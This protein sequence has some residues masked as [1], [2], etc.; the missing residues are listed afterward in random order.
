MAEGDITINTLLWVTA[1]SFLPT[2]FWLWFWLREDKKKPEPAGLIALTFIAGMI[3]VFIVFPLQWFSYTFVSGT[4]L[5]V[6][7]AITEE[8]IKYTALYV[9]ALRSRFFDEPI[10]A[11]VYAITVALGFS[12]MENFLYMVN[13]IQESGLAL[14]ALNGNLRFVGATILHTVSSAAVGIAIAFAF[15]KVAW[16]KTWY[17]LAGLLTASAL[18]AVFNLSIINTE[19]MGEILTVFFYLWILVLILLIFF[20][21][22]KRIH[23][24]TPPPRAQ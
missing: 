12:A 3:S 19:S 11:V 7:F 2:L 5:L 1:G 13:V 8:V 20:E 18:H 21:K 6:V 17:L 24:P 16:E 4:T 15:Y 14:G 10:D 23:R 9:V 22:I